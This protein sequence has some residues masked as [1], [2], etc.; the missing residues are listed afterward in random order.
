MKKI[1]LL[2]VIILFVGCNI[3]DKCT[4]PNRFKGC[5]VMAKSSFI[6][7]RMRLKL[8]DSLS[9]VYDKDYI[10]IRVPAF[11]ASKYHCGDVIR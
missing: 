1:V 11:E 4:A 3:D 9:V 2:L 6:N 5:E 7:A 10:T 8:T